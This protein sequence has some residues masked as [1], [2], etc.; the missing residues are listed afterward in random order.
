VKRIA[1]RTI[2][3]DIENGSGWI[4]EDDNGDTRPTPDVERIELAIEAVA[5]AL[6][7]GT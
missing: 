7:R 4:Y 3:A 2:R 1:A 5:T 6:E